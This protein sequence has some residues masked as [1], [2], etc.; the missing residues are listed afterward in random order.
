MQVTSENLRQISIFAGL[1]AGELAQ[2]Q[3]HAAVR[4]YLRGEIIL[5]EGDPAASQAVW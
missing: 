1:R 3:R 4:A 2:I 5:R